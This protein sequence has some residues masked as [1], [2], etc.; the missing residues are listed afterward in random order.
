MSARSNA[1]R[2]GTDARTTRHA[3]TVV[4]WVCFVA[5]MSVV[6][7]VLILTDP[8]PPPSM[9]RAL[10]QDD[11][12]PVRRSIFD[13]ANPLE[14]RRFTSIVLYDTGSP[15]ASIEGLARLAA[16][17]GSHGIPY[18][19]VI[20]NG[21]GMGDGELHVGYRWNEQLPGAHLGGPETNALDAR[22][23]TICLV[24]NGNIRPFT[25][26]QMDRLVALVR[27]LQ[28]R[29]GIPLDEVYLLRDLTGTMSPGRNF[30][31]STFRE[32]LSLS[33]GG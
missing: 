20:G 32:Q 29:L 3:R 28:E 6:G 33:V 9:G 16:A 24:G 11:R 4:V 27:A 21:N 22:A 8:T 5:V 31:T 12:T 7:S 19:F 1:S 26:P 23:I 15:H 10:Y 18:H 17:N 25:Q 2:T 30:P 14:E 13:T